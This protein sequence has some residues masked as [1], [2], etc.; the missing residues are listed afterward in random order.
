MIRKFRRRKI[1][2]KALESL[3]IMFSKLRKRTRK[4]KAKPMNRTMMQR[5]AMIVLGWL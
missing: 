5:R 1:K 2:S 3:S 4:R